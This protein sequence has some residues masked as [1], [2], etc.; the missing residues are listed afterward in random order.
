MKFL[1]FL[2]HINALE[3]QFLFKPQTRTSLLMDQTYLSEF[4]WI[5]V[6]DIAFHR[7]P[8]RL[9]AVSPAVR[10]HFGPLFALRVMKLLGSPGDALVLCM[11]IL[12][13]ADVGL[14]DKAEHERL[15]TMQEVDGSG[16]M[17]WMYKYGAVVILIGNK[18]LTMA[19]AI[20]ALKEVEA[21]RVS[22]SYDII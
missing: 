21:L 9:I 11:R 22:S 6:N 4:C 3:G 5:A 14:C 12:V 7:R 8:R 2:L 15:L 19:L 1:C 20:N 16:P 10:E 18:R 13:A 17:G